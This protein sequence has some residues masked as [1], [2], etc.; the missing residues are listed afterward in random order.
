MPAGIGA[1]DDRVEAGVAGCAVPIQDVGGAIAVVVTHRDY[2]V[3]R[4]GC[5]DIV[6]AGNCAID[7]GVEAGV[8]VGIIPIEDVGSAVA[9]EVAYA[10]HAIGRGGRAD[11]DPG[12][13]IDERLGVEAGVAGGI[14]S[15]QDVRVAVV[16]EIACPD[17]AVGGGGGADVEPAGMLKKRIVGIVHLV[18]AGVA[19]RVVPVQEVRGAV[20][21]EVAYSHHAVGGRGRPDVVPPLQGASAV[22]HLIVAGIAGGAVRE[23]DVGDA[24][25]IEV[26]D[27]DRRVGGGGSADIVPGLKG[28]I[29]DLVKTGIAAAIIAEQNVRRAIAIVIVGHFQIGGDS[30]AADRAGAVCACV[31]KVCAAGG[32]PIDEYAAAES[33]GIAAVIIVAGGIVQLD[34]GL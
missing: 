21:I 9:V 10:N 25:N 14:V 19:G 18:I 32:A 12:P 16:I 20:E 27:S 5:P 2:A 17:H 1:V 6:P 31:E 34:A 23:Q 29:L 30:I 4:R 24:V 28:A 7:D 3:G 13:R 33:V 22:V 26:A 8:A 11:V 15:E